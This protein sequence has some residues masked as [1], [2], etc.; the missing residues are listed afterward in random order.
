M[1]Y[2]IVNYFLTLGYI[3]SITISI[4]D[5]YWCGGSN[6]TV[7]VIQYPSAKSSTTICQTKLYGEFEKDGIIVYD[8]KQARTNI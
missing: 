4:W 2:I 6:V 8:H 7:E 3:E 1:M 5:H